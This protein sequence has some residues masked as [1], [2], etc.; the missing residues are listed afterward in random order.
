MWFLVLILITGYYLCLSCSSLIRAF[1]S[2]VI[3]TLL[4]F[5]IGNS[6]LKLSF[7]QVARVEARKPVRRSV[8]K[9]RKELLAAWTGV[10]VAKG[11][12]RGCALA[13]ESTGVRDGVN[14][15]S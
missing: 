15:E 3:L 6:T 8:E 2:V 12:H 11:R 7:M 9:H 1:Q 14:V 5:E 10:V 13:G 4:V